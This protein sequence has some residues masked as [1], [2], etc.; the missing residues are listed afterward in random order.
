MVENEMKR[1]NNKHGI[2]IEREF[3]KYDE[4]AV[5]GTGRNKRSRQSRQKDKL[6]WSLSRKKL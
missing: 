4:K 6:S 5:R 3:D 1:N 2:I